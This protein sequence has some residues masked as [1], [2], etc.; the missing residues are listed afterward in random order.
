MVS[1]ASGVAIGWVRIRGLALQKKAKKEPSK[2]AGIPHDASL[3][4]KNIGQN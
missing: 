4:V 2:N 3:S 1:M